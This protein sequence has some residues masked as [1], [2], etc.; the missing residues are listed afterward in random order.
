MS[1]WAEIMTIA[2]DRRDREIALGLALRPVLAGERPDWGALPDPLARRR[3]GYLVDLVQHFRGQSEAE[4]AELAAVREGLG[5]LAP[6]PFW[7]GERAPPVP[8]D[9]IAWRWGYTRGVDLARLRRALQGEPLSLLPE[10]VR[11]SPR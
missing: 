2:H 3:L 9:P 11:A 5:D 4:A 1:R 6:E 10:A 8:A 7:P